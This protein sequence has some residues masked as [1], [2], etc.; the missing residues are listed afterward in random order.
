MSLWLEEF[1]LRYM[2]YEWLNERFSLNWDENTILKLSDRTDKGQITK[3]LTEVSPDE[4][5]QATLETYTDFKKEFLE[6]NWNKILK[7]N[8]TLADYI[9]RLEY[10][11]KVIHEMGY[12]TYFLIVQDYI[13]YGKKHN[14]VVWPWRWS[15]AWSLLGYLIRITEIDPLEYDLLFERF[16]NPARVSMPDID[17]DF[18][19]S[20]RDKILEYCKQKYWVEKVAN[21]WTYMTMAAK[22]SFKDVA[23]VF[24]LSFTKANQLSGYIEKSILKSYEENEEFKSLVDEDE[25][26]KK[27][28]NFASRLE[29]NV[30]QLWVHACWVIIAPEKI[31]EYT[32]VQYPIKSG[33]KEVDSTRVVT[34]Y[35]GHY[36]EDIGLLKMDFLWL[37]NLSIIKNTLKILKAKGLIWGQKSKN[38][39]GWG[40]Q[41]KSDEGKKWVLPS[42]Y[43]KFFDYYV[44]EPPI[45]DKATYEIFQKWDTVW[46]F[47]FESD[48]MRAWLKKLKPTNI[49]DIIAMVSLY[50][51]WPME[52]IPNYIDRK[53]W[54]EE[55]TYL[56][57][58]VYNELVKKYWKEV[59]EQQ[60][61]QITED[62]SWFMDVTYWIPV[63]QEQL[64]RIVQA[65]AWFSLGEADLLRRWVG[66]KIK[67]VIEKLKIEFIERASKYKDYKEE[68]SRFVYE[69]MIEPA[70]NYSFN[71][72]H[73]A[74]YAIIAYQTAYLKAH[75]PVEFYAALLRSVEENTDRFAELLEE[76]KIKWIKV[77]PVNV[78]YSY[79]HIAAVDDA[80]V[81]WFLA[82]KGIWFEVWEHIEQERLKN[83]PYKNLEDFLTRNEEYINKKTLEALIKSWA[84]DDFESRVVLINNIENILDWL[85]KSQ[86]KQQTAWMGLFG[87]EILW[88][89]PL[90]LKSTP[91]SKET[92][93]DKLKLEYE[94]FWTFVSAHPFDGLYS[95]IKKKYNFI[96]QVE[97][98]K[99]EWDYIL[100]GF[101]KDIVKSPKFWWYF[102]Q[103][104][105]IT[106][107]TRFFLKNVPWLNKFDVIEIRWQK[108]W[109][110]LSV[111]KILKLDIELL[112]EKLKSKWKYKE[113]ELVSVVRA[114][115]GDKNNA[116]LSE[117]IVNDPICDTN[118]EINNDSEM[119]DSNYEDISIDKVEYYEVF[120]ELPDNIEEINKLIDMKKQNPT[121]KEFE[122]NWK[123]YLI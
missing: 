44:F 71:K 12:D 90:V 118:C 1:Q 69:K 60:R 78:N 110:R 116:S 2:W 99:Y 76:L 119:K 92:L 28:V 52:W 107:S 68:V 8:F 15:A 98:E 86:V 10:E 19:D 111:S 16:L 27:I 63:Y 64:M 55:I 104:E 85:K 33:S 61:K 101:I 88:K 3:K 21:I 93:M 87:E 5:K 77:K 25:E 24:W 32:P 54:K 57:E 45:D 109:K 47:Q 89:D 122:L 7:K 123:I 102:I 73:A 56:P 120:I 113:N 40:S 91:G 4:L 48:G 26:L 51:P 82:I 20:E 72:S 70:A 84:L 62:L 41:M 31:T 108:K 36:L 121:Q 39:I 67:E 96:T 37:R 11:L 50:R 29:W 30:R 17:T 94:A 66:K 100:I 53:Q 103:V 81:V 35:D 22:A 59:A 117:N 49:D 6:K 75:H 9:N 43:E 95:Y 112:I 83:G 46:V 23:R 80:V 14:I 97:D 58:D 65:M 115:R 18:E 13:M 105:D 106:G 38:E 114:E 42:F 79:N 34:Q 74:C